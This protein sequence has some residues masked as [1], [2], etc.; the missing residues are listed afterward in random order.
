MNEVNRM[1]DG[2]IE[3]YNKAVMDTVK[4][5]KGWE[6]NGI[7]A[8][9]A[10]CASIATLL[11]CILECSESLDGVKDVL[12]YCNDHVEEHYKK[13]NERKNNLD[14]DTKTEI[15]SIRE[16]IMKERVSFHGSRCPI[17]EK[18]KEKET[19]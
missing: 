3:S 8:G 9:P 11:N 19:K 12:K 17:E 7:L 18:L 4:M 5:L 14:T 13:M 15:D 1:S 16:G 2:E 6:E 10:M